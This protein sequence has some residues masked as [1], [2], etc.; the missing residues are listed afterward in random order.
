MK[1]IRNKELQLLEQREKIV[2]LF[3]YLFMD[4]MKIWEGT[5]KL[6]IFYLKKNNVDL[7]ATSNSGHYLVDTNADK[8]DDFQMFQMSTTAIPRKTSPIA[9]VTVVA[10]ISPVE[11]VTRAPIDK[12]KSQFQ[13]VTTKFSK[14]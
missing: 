3:H 8:E 1:L 5:K 6:V 2:T 11:I 9:V 10:T 4:H 12:E 7:T 14:C 13:C